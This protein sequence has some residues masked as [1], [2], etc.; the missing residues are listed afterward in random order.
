MYREKDPQMNFNEILPPFSNTLDSENRWVKLAALIPWDE[1]ENE[2][3]AKFGKTGNVAF[4]LRMAL[5]SLI[6]QEKKGLSNIELVQEII[7]SRYLQYFIGLDELTNTAPF[8]QSALTRFRQRLGADIINRV[9]Q[10]I[11][12]AEKERKKNDDDKDSNTSP[13]SEGMTEEEKPVNKGKLIL[14]ATCAPADITYPTDAGLLNKAREKTEEMIDLLHEPLRGVM[15][16]PRTYREKA[17]KDFLTYSKNRNGRKTT[18]K[19]ACKK[20]LGYVKRNLGT[21][22]KLMDTDGTGKLSEKKLDELKV[23]AELYRQQAYMH[24]NNTH[25]VDD[26]IVNLDQH[27]VRPIKRGKVS[28]ETEFGAKVSISVVDGYA[29]VERISW[30]NYNESSDLIK[31][32]EQYRNE[33]GCYPEAV[34]ADKIYRKRKNLNYCR[35]RGIRLSGLPLGRPPKDYGK[36]KESRRLAYQD[37]C[38]RNA[39]EGKF[40]EAKNIGSLGRLTARLKDTS[41]AQIS[42]VFLVLNLNKV[43]RDLLRLF[44]EWYIECKYR[45]YAVVKTA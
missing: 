25:Q 1:F 44:F 41:E 35:D 11:V 21:I 39:V 27:W 37:S 40:G 10:K 43:L 29:K 7:E 30:N 3:A 45:F 36:Q 32:V 23:I 26:R 16:K 24:E 18:W 17:R 14:D 42:M 15:P 4:P 2:Y 8:D 5:G 12:E 9:N 34:Q 28:A 6:I 19:K 31:A 38:E 33:R 20:Q 22:K 13:K